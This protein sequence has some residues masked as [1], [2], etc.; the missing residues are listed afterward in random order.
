MAAPNTSVPLLQYA[1]Y[2]W[3]LSIVPR[4][5]FYMVTPAESTYETLKEIP[6]YVTQS[7]PFWFTLMFVEHLI[8]RYLG[9]R[10]SRIN[11]TFSSIGS[12]M[13]Q[14]MTR[15]LLLGFELSLYQYVYDH[16]HLVDLPWD[17]RW[18]WWLCILG[19]D[20]GYYWAHRAGHE[21]NFLWA[22][23]QVHHSSESY[24]LTTALRQSMFQGFFFWVFYMPLALVIPAP[25]FK[26][27]G[28]FNLIYQFW[29]HTELVDNLGPLEWILNTPSHHRVHHG[30]N[31]KCLDKNYAAVFI[32]W[33]R[34]F[35]TF[36]P[37]PKERNVAYGL[38]YPLDVWDPIAAQFHYY[39]YILTKA[40]NAKGLSI[41][42]QILF[43]GPGWTPP[44]EEVVPIPEVQY[45][46]KVFNRSLPTLL[47][48]Y[49]V[50]QYVLLM[51][52]YF[53]LMD[54]GIA[55]LP[56][57]LGVSY[58]TFTLTCMG[59][60]LDH[61]SYALG[62]EVLRCAVVLLLNTHPTAI[63]MVSTFFFPAPLKMA[64]MAAVGA[65]MLLSLALMAH[66]ASGGANYWEKAA[67]AKKVQ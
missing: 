34:M 27:H 31:E 18:L 43:R 48:G 35:G 11:D 56:M 29:I 62:I 52:P 23:H 42:L 24:N 19:Y 9:K 67:A 57:W 39:Q 47:L 63:G 46:V 14:Q 8:A 32:I 66:R 64:G 30:R 20:F 58:V 51:P 45:P 17:S 16:Y 7:V 50:V 21:I 4:A 55:T 53:S 15:V 59:M 49:L 60:M 65:S 28:Q 3:D 41:K 37:E 22:A 61:K 13:I 12:G 1:S 26:I 44:G 33:D 40:W 10:S 36:E 6:D 2:A 25:I 38:V 5:N 54:K